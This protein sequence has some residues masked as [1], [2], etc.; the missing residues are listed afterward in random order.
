[1]R[2]IIQGIIEGEPMAR[3]FLPLRPFKSSRLWSSTVSRSP[4][5]FRQHVRGSRESSRVK[6]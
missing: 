3:T 1:V 4:S 6:V 2:I 5:E